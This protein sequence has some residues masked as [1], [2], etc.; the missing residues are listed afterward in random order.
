MNGIEG[1]EQRPE[2]ESIITHPKYAA[3][4]NHDYDVAL[5]K[6]KTPIKY[7]SRVRPVCLP[8]FDFSDDTMCYISGW[9]HT[10]EGGDVPQVLRS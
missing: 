3:H 8:K 9:G 2:I 6:L 10:T 5:I 4:K 7:N 1:Y